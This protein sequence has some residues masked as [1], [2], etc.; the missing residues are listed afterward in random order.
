MAYVEISSQLG[1]PVNRVYGYVSS[2]LGKLRSATKEKA[3]E[4][5]ELEKLRLDQ[6]YEKIQANIAAGSL[7]DIE[8][9]LKIMARRA[10]LEGLDAAVEVNSKITVAHLLVAVPA[11]AEDARDLLRRELGDS[12]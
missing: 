10:K 11:T 12:F 1:I 8:V 4:V 6:M 2:A 7:D 3:D 9:G 5:R